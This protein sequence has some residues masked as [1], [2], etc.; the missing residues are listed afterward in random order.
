MTRRSKVKN[1][2][3]LGCYH[4][5]SLCLLASCVITG[6]SLVEEDLSGCED[7]SEVNYELDLVTNVSTE[8]KT[9]LET[10]LSTEST[11]EA[12]ADIELAQE[13]REYL[14]GVFTDFAHDISLSFY[15][16]QGDSMRLQHEQHI[17]DANQ[18]SYTLNLPRQH[19]MHLAVANLERN[20][21]VGL[22]YGD[23]CHT[24][25]LDQIEVD[26]IDSHTTG[27]FTARLPMNVVEGIDQS[28]L[29]RLFMA[30]CSACLVIDPRGHD[31][32]G[33]QVFTTGFATGFSICDSVYHFAAKSPMVRTKRLDTSMKNR[34]AFCSVNFPS[35]SLS[36]TRTVIETSEPFVSKTARES[37]WEFCVLVPQKDGKLSRTLIH[38]WQPLMPGQLK[39]VRVWMNAD[40]SLS[41]DASEVSTSVELDWKPGL[42]I[43]M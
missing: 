2:P 36:N 25:M 26:T 18:A 11:V 37:L 24:S 15:D 17:M 43:E 5:L 7:N 31:T 40:G 10:Q 9:Q 3:Q 23:R 16:T 22:W 41:T 38:I 1:H 30:N 27:V 32:Q 8:I 13:L 39:I 33:M 20:E 6:C 29:V 34:V 19:Y 35:R 42:V 14:S 12:A 28:F 21:F 4:V